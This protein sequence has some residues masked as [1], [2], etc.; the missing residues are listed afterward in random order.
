MAYKQ[1]VIPIRFALLPTVDKNE[2][3][4]FTH[5]VF[6][7]EVLHDTPLDVLTEAHV[8]MC[9]SAC[10]LFAQCLRELAKGM[11]KILARL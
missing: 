4:R 5:S 6:F 1:R 2:I 8:L 10:R 7:V 9:S 11:Q 3:K